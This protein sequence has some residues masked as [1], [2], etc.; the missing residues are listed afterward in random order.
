MVNVIPDLFLH[1][2]QYVW[3]VSSFE[4]NSKILTIIL[5]FNAIRTTS[6]RRF[7]TPLTVGLRVWSKYFI[8][9]DIVR[10]WLLT[11]GSG[12]IS[13]HNSTSMVQS[14]I[15]A[16]HA[17]SLNTQIKIT[18]VIFIVWPI[19]IYWYAHKP[20]SYYG[21]KISHENL[22]NGW[23]SEVRSL[24]SPYR[25]AKVLIFQRKY[26]PWHLNLMRNRC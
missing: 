20:Y 15:P 19:S 24:M 13:T 11:L 21:P 10:H 5:L 12:V 4:K 7:G 22:K 14:V 3:D 8:E 23:V 25:R 18:C 26:I 17:T 16:K 2:G 6:V 1:D 9:Q